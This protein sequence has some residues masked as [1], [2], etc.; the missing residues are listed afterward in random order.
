M[1]CPSSHV[2]SL[3]WPII[4]IMLHIISVQHATVFYEYILYMTSVIGNVCGDVDPPQWFVVDRD[5]AFQLE[6]DAV[7]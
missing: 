6:G 3:A 1:Y 5:P 2:L 4:P 7:F